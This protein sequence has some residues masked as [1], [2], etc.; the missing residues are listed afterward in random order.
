MH[1]TLSLR[2]TDWILHFIFLI[3]IIA[4]FYI[5]KRPHLR[6]PWQQVFKSTAGMATFTILAIFIIIAQFDS[7]HFVV[8]HLDKSG[9]PRITQNLT[10]F[11]ILVG[12]TK[13]RSEKTY[14]KPLAI[15]SLQKSW[16]VLPNGKEAYVH[17]RLT[18]GGKHLSSKNEI[19]P[20][21]SFKIFQGALIGCGLSL[22][23]S[24]IFLITYK[25]KLKLNWREATKNLTRGNTTL[26]WRTCIITLSC[27]F[28]VFS[29]L[30]Q[31]HL[32][33][34]LFGT[35]KIGQDI[36]LDT[37]KSIRTAILIGTLTTLFMLPFALFF[38][39][40][41]GYFGGWVD[42]I[43][44]YLYTT[45]SAIP[46]VLL[47]SAMVLVMQ[48]YITNHPELFPTLADRADA[49]LLTL[50][51][52]LGLTSWASLCRLLRAETLK[53][54]EQDFVTA[55][56]S[57]GAKKIPIIVRHILPN[58]MHIIVITI[59]LDFSGLVMAE[60]ILS[61][62]GV[63]VDPTTSSW[64][65]IINSSRLELAREPMVWW[66]LLAALV[67]MFLLVLTANLFADVVRDAFDPR[68]REL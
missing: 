11:D 30:M 47:I 67:F 15:H 33:Y 10:L 4:V 55:A 25:I 9:Q 19:I 56:I 61:Y 16:V 60:A 34:Y 54:R 37:I 26:A 21:L 38:G 48:I 17:Q 68:L 57:M 45:I 46:G 12:K 53:I 63:G 44:Q 41:A 22:C 8:T 42:D 50:C 49:R 7:I 52:I 14:S 35:D 36:F 66:P 1:L 20:D 27:I 23:L 24:F 39:T 18:H 62:V 6:T 65:N 32:A 2:P 28:I 31:L 58:V 5:R 59:V 51:L 40:I 3:C 64:G 43:I 13:P 29:I